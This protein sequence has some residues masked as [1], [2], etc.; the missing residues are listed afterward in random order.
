MSQSSWY[1]DEADWE[2]P[3]LPASAY[4]PE[5]TACQKFFLNIFMG[6]FYIIFM[7]FYVLTCAGIIALGIYFARFI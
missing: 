3:P 7:A 1:E 4:P 6:I 2:S 5:E